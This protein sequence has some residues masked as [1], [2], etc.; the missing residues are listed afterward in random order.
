MSDSPLKGKHI[1]LGISGGIAAYK[2]PLLV[3]LYTKA[4][5]HVQ[6]LLTKS[7]K[8]FVTP[9]TLQTL[10][11][12]PVIS[13]LFDLDFE[14]D[15]GHIKMADTADLMVIAPCTAN[16]MAKLAHGM[17]DDIVTTVALATKAPILLAPSMNVNMW[18]HPS[19][20][21]NLEILTKDL[22]MTTVGPESGDLA[23]KW[24]GKGRLSEPADIFSA[25]EACIGPGSLSGKTVLVSAGG[26]REHFDPVR[27]LGNPSSGK[28]GYAIAE[29]AQKEGARVILV[30]GKSALD[31]PAGVERHDVV[32]AAEMH[33]SVFEHLKQA[34]VLV[35]AAA[36]ADYRPKDVSTQK[37]KKQ[38]GPWQVEFERTK[39]I[40]A[41]V[42][43]CPDRPIMVVGFAAETERLL[44]HAESKRKKK[45]LD[46]VVANRVGKLG[47]GFESDTNKAFIVTEGKSEEFASMQKTELAKEIIVRIVER[48]SD[49]A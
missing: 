43:E 26:T 2:I 35:M 30:S 1:V 33:R 36:V 49:E 4:G 45:N 41:E 22:D 29:A 31:T 44:E 21:R 37:R 14:S 28:M 48:L 10:S 12:N 9:L 32:S 23:C 20:Q 17:A 38:D 34:D 18:N 39:D 19:T 46:M 42:S 25:S 11:G 40:L 24:E 5:A 15:I 3:R 27:Y 16:T 47:G 13:E 7:A 6:V 8:E